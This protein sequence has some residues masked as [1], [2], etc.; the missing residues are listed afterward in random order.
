MCGLPA[1]VHV[2]FAE[3]VVPCVVP[4][5]VTGAHVEA[6]VPPSPV[7]AVVPPSLPGTSGVGVELEEELLEHALEHTTEAQRSGSTSK[8]VRMRPSRRHKKGRGKR[9]Y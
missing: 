3:M 4:A 9:T 2:S 6:T 1:A 8:R 5:P 7:I